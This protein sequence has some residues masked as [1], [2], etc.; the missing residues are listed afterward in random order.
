MNQVQKSRLWCDTCQ[1]NFTNNAEFALHEFTKKH[2]ENLLR[3]AK[4]KPVIRKQKSAKV[5][6]PPEKEEPKVNVVTTPGSF[7]MYGYFVPGEFY[8]TGE[9]HKEFNTEYDPYLQ[10]F[11]ENPYKEKKDDVTM[12]QAA[13]AMPTVNITSFSRKKKKKIRTCQICNVTLLTVPEYE[14]HMRS[15]QHTW[16]LKMSGMG[17]SAHFVKAST[18]LHTTDVNEDS[19]SNDAEEETTDVVQNNNP[20]VPFPSLFCDVCELLLNSEQQYNCHVNGKTHQECVQRKAELKAKKEKS[21]NPIPNQL[22]CYSCKL[23]LNNLFQYNEHK[24]GKKHKSKCRLLMREGITIPPEERWGASRLDPSKPVKYPEQYEKYVLETMEEVKMEVEKPVPETSTST[25]TI[26]ANLATGMYHCDV[27]NAKFNTA[28][29]YDAHAK[30]KEHSARLAEVHECTTCKRIFKNKKE[31]EEHNASEEHLQSLNSKTELKQNTQEPAQPVLKPAIVFHNKKVENAEVEET[32]FLYHCNVCNLEFRFT[33][34]ELKEHLEDPNHKSK[35]APAPATVTTNEDIKCNICDVRFDVQNHFEYHLGTEEHARKILEVKKNGMADDQILTTLYRDKKIV[36]PDKFGRYLCSICN[37]KSS[38]LI[39][40]NQHLSSVVHKYTDKDFKRKKLMEVKQAVQP[41]EEGKYPCKLCK[42][43]Y[44][45]LVEYN[46]HLHSSNHKSIQRAERAKKIAARRRSILLQQKK[47]KKKNFM[48]ALRRKNF[49]FWRKNDEKNPGVRTKIS[50]I[51]T[52]LNTGA[53]A[54]I[55]NL[56]QLEPRIDP[57]KNVQLGLKPPEDQEK[58]PA[59]KVKVKKR[60]RKQ[61]SSGNFQ[62]PPNNIPPLVPP[63]GLPP[64]PPPPCFPMNQNWSPYPPPYHPYRM[65]PFNNRLRPLFPV[66]PFP[67][68][69][70]FPQ[71]NWGRFPPGYR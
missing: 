7:A 60:K 57:V 71:P 26:T 23:S 63:Q 53:M 44:P 3:K 34:Q 22:Y 4:N 32:G 67:G 51:A 56:E 15:P 46:Q 31:V 69:S 13:A 37:V 55:P 58:E 2:C 65:R 25:S 27:C 36:K 52:D 10:K 17:V 30:S 33:H 14:A 24:N 39:E 45:T 21:Q 5:E 20:V 48:S 12:A 64:P 68:P 35:P 54:S 42:E 49:G 18:D 28:S 16:K 59:K 70:R 8:N 11:A 66:N 41:D 47:F 38:N 1:I 50:G 40:F 29:K 43:S 6:P 62:I 61:D 9:E 19:N